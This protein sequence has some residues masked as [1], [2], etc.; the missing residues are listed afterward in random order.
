MRSFRICGFDYALD[1]K[2]KTTAIFDFC[3]LNLSKHPCVQMLLCYVY[4]INCILLLLTGC[5]FCTFSIHCILSRRTCL[6]DG[7]RTLKNWFKPEPGF[8]AAKEDGYRSEGNHNC[9]KKQCLELWEISKNISNT[10]G[11]YVPLLS[12]LAVYT[13]TWHGTYEL[14]NVFILV[15]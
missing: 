12:N 6:G 4:S 11:E 2:H 15:P 7:A 8:N 9:L 3:S 1:M 14:N 13:W 5:S 10:E